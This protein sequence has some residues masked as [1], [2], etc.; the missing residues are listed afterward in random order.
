M[1]V[2][3]NLE[4]ENL[5]NREIVF[6]E[7]IANSMNTAGHSALLDSECREL[8]IIGGQLIQKILEKLSDEEKEDMYEYVKITNEKY[9]HAMDFCYARGFEDGFVYRKILSSCT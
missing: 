9:L 7:Y 4:K 3:V 2:N 8:T 5:K 6:R 1:A